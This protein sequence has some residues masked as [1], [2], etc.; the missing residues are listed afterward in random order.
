MAAFVVVTGGFIGSSFMFAAMT[1]VYY[2]QRDGHIELG[3][4]FLPYKTRWNLTR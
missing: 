3:K 1:Y 4:L 2:F